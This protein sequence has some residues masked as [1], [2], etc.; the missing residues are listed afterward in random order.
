ME[1]TLLST[2]EELRFIFELLAAELVF[3]VPF[4]PARKGF[5]Q[6]VVLQFIGYGLTSM[7]YF[8][9]LNLPTL[10]EIRQ[11][12]V[13]G[14]YILFALSTI[15]FC[16][17]L[18]EIGTVDSLY[19]IAS[20]YAVSHIVYVL[21]HEALA[22]YYWQFLQ[23]HLFLYIVFSI[24]VCGILYLIIYLLFTRKLRECNGILYNDNSFMVLFYL[25]F[26]AVML[27]STFSAQHLF[28]IGDEVRAFGIIWGIS[29]CALILGIQYANFKSTLANREQAII[30]R[31]LQ[32]SA[33]HYTIS[34]ELIDLV[35]RNAHD[36]KHKLRAL[37]NAPTQL[38]EDFIDEQMS[39]IEDYQ[40]LVFC[41]N[42]VLNTIL[43]EKSLYC[44]SMGITFSCSV[45][46][47]K[48]D[49]IDVMDLYAI[50]GN[51]IDNAI[52]CVLKFTEKSK[53]VISVNVSSREAFIIIQVE[54]YSGG[55]TSTVDELP[56]T[57]KLTIGHGFGLKSIKYIANKYDGNMYW[58]DE[59]GV[60][61]LQVM[62]PIPVVPV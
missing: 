43:A 19:V 13:S 33:T 36:L 7:C 35:N 46:K 1:I 5:K 10:P 20:S 24:V 53:R 21:V 8:L 58:A 3:L 9:L 56:A 41:D 28:W 15:V 14:W 32:D 6:N 52:E 49:F 16:K 26:I 25:I 50:L 29:T 54:N 31:M 42:E 44:S 62:F 47:C 51:A 59:D 27:I 17:T 45:K 34:K 60:F 23:R 37:K 30:A 39:H 57:T 18:F 55:I 2:F 22:L 11:W 38:R 12:L 40:N 61:S 4:V 48:L